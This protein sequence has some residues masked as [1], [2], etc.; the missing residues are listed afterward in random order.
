MFKF[1]DDLSDRAQFEAAYRRL[2]PLARRVADG[3]LRD[4]AAAEDVVQDV[5]MALWR[6][7]S[8]YDPARGTLQTYVALLAQSRSLD[9]RRSRSAQAAAYERLAH[10]PAPAPNGDPL[11]DAALRRERERHV[12]LAVGELPADQRDAVLAFGHGLSA[13]EIASR[14]RLPLGTAKSRIRLGLAKARA[15]LGETG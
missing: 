15:W 11:V 7:P 6:N 5:F 13:S 12:L 2:A 4:A 8:A 3:V 10:E 1:V 14:E 9:R